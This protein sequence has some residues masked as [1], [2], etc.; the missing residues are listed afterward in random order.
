MPTGVGLRKWYAVGA[1]VK[2]VCI[3]VVF[4]AGIVARGLIPLAIIL[5]L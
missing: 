2:M 1:I 4:V 5:W 3:G